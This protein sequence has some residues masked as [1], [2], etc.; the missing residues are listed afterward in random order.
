[1]ND[2]K[3]PTA[4]ASAEDTAL[5]EA[6]PPAEQT[7]FDALRAEIEVLRKELEDSKAKSEQHWNLYLTAEAEMQNVRRRAERDKQDAHRYALEKFI[8]ELLPVKDSLE[9]GIAAA[10]DTVDVQKLREGSELTLKMLAATIEK[11]GVKE[12]NPLGEKF[13]PALHQA[14]AMQPSD[15]A[16]PNTVLQVIQKGYLLNDR[17]VRPALVIV[18]RGSG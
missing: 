8:G 2:E 15:Q 18:A 1:M 14:V 3:Q 4:A 11:F 7:E 5:V 6:T 9:L 17:L 10:Q 13:D 16:E 12:L